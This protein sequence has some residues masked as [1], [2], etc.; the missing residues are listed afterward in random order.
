[1]ETLRFEAEGC[2][3]VLLLERK[4]EEGIPWCECYLE[5]DGISVWFGGESLP[6]VADRFQRI[7]TMPVAE[8]EERTQRYGEQAFTVIAF[9]GTWTSVEALYEDG[10]LRLL[11]R[12][13]HLVLLGETRLDVDA[14]G[15]WLGQFDRLRGLSPVAG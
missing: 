4:A 3:F 12:D 7:L 2:A 8:L 11:W 1:M 15:R 9:A 6:V 14:R 5:R 13:R 10:R